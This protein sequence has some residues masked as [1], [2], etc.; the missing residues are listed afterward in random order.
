VSRSLD[1]LPV[2]RFRRL[3]RDE[4]DKLVELGAFRDE[5]IELLYGRLVE[6]TPQ[7]A[8]HANAVMALADLLTRGLGTRAYVR[9]QLPI[10][11]SEDSEPEP[12]LAVVARD[13]GPAHPREAHLI[14]EISENSLRDDRML[15]LPIYARMGVREYWIVNLVD[16]V[17]EVYR[18][19]DE[20]SGVYRTVSKLGRG[21]QLS[22]GA[23]PDVI[24]SI[25][26]A[27]GPR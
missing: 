4:Y 22:C 17:F 7:G 27:L 23:F 21:Q 14:V 20:Q 19:V 16:D 3:K 24:V 9:T 15:K 6:M 8:R 5:K 12:D 11:A 18:D 26:E 25:D 13:R 10:A 2:A 1:D